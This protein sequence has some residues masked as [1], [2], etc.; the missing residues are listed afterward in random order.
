MNITH[1]I[2]SLQTGGA[3]NMLI[4]I[5]HEQVLL[6]HAVT[7]IIVNKK[8]NEALKNTI[9]LEVKI[10][11]LK[12]PEGSKNPYYFFKLYYTLYLQ[13]PDVVHCHNVQMGKILKYYKGKK[14]ITVHAT[15]TY[16]PSLK[17]FDKVVS[18]SKAVHDSLR[19]DGDLRNSI[20]HNGIN[21]DN[22]KLKQKNIN[23][24]NYKILQVGRLTHAQKGQDLSIKAIAKLKD[25]IENFNITL[26]FIGEG[27]SET[28]LKDLVD[29]L[30]LNSN[31][32]FWGNKDKMYIYEHLKEYDLLIQPSRYEGFGL[33][34]IEGMAAKIPVLV[35]DIEG[36]MEVIQSGKLG[37]YFVCDNSD[38]L[39]EKIRLLQ[40]SISNEKVEKA[41]R[42]TLEN[43]TIEKTV[44]KYIVLYERIRNG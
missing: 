14:I 38:S 39:A 43:Y 6:G 11:E 22:I 35:S 13:Q 16:S 25:S 40:Y 3:E 21:T 1:I 2:F 37:E 28:Y 7:L 32:K 17:Y 23:S 29:D 24:S 8:V 31:I 42:Y 4:D 9:H 27:S 36:P 41:Y 5:M 33:T 20:I 19:A 30:D 15:D 10:I 12:R 18:I 34:I 44:E 26:T